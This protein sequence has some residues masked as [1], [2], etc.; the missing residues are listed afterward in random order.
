VLD[1]HSSHLN[2]FG[3]KATLVRGLQKTDNVF[4]QLN[5]RAHVFL[6]CA[7]EFQDE[8]S[9]Q[10]LNSGFDRLLQILYSKGNMVD[11]LYAPHGSLLLSALV[12][13]KI[14][15][16]YSLLFALRT[17]YRVPQFFLSNDQ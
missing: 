4:T 13:L 14:S 17:I 3:H 6:L 2:V 7:F 5:A 12:I 8:L 10:D 15:T 9:A 11:S 1:A 16:P